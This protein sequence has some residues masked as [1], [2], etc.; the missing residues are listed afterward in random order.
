MAGMDED[1]W[2]RVGGGVVRVPGGQRWGPVDVEKP[3]PGGPW[4]A[5]ESEGRLVGWAPRNA[6]IG[7]PRRALEESQHLVADRR[8]HLVERLGHKLRSSVLALQESARQAAFGRPE[9]LEQLYDQAQE[10]QRRASALEAVA[11]E[12]TEQ[13]RSVVLGAVLN[14]A[15]PHAQRDVPPE[16]IVHG[17][18]RVLV[19]A[20][21]RTYEWMGGEGS[22]IQG[23]RFGEWWELV[24]LAA[25]ERS[26]LPVPE[27]G[28]PLV[29]LLVDAHLGGW[30]DSHG[31]G[32]VT[33][34]LPAVN[35]G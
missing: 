23:S 31:D 6:G 10:V 22:G 20:L 26:P 15:A 25:P 30:L 19:E 4:K 34:Y 27:L 33:I 28:A 8:A 16:A 12:P 29:G 13:P 11:V 35:R 14:L 21:T 7:A 18:E 3:P 1:L 9:L 24:F 5:L 32:R 17:A 2:V